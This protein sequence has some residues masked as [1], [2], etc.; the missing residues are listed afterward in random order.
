MMEEKKTKRLEWESLLKQLQEERDIKSQDIRSAIEG[1]ITLSR[2]LLRPGAESDPKF[3]R[4]K[5]S[6]KKFRSQLWRFSSVRRLLLASGWVRDEDEETEDGRVYP[7]IRL[8]TNEYLKDL[9]HLLL[10][11]RGVTPLANE[12]V[13]ASKIEQTL[14]EEAAL[15]QAEKLKLAKERNEAHRTALE[16]KRKQ[17]ELADLIKIQQKDDQERLRIRQPLPNKVYM[18]RLYKTRALPNSGHPFVPKRG[19]INPGLSPFPLVSHAVPT[20]GPTPGLDPHAEEGELDPETDT[21]PTR[22][23]SEESD[24]E[25]QNEGGHVLG[26]E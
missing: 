22:S 18:D 16:E 8:A 12:W 20:P 10:E 4:Q 19:V 6:D 25:P 17:K 23:E 21:E 11:H 3:C 1:L 9:I 7:V 2:N 26:R 14:D 24:D 15:R 13:Q 5:S